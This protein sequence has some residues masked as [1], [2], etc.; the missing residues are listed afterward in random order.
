MIQHIVSALSTRLISYEA[1]IVLLTWLTALLGAA[2]VFATRKGDGHPQTLRGLMAFLL[3]QAVWRHRSPRLDV[4][5]HLAQHFTLPILAVPFLL[6]NGTA[7]AGV[8]HQLT[9]LFGAHA[10]TDASLPLWVAALAISLLTADFAT[11]AMHYL[12]HKI[13][14]LWD[15]HKTHH[16][17]EFLIPL[18]KHRIHPVEVVFDVTSNAALVGAANGVLAYVFS[19]PIYASTVLGLDVYFLANLLSFY[20]LRHS[21][22]DMSYGN[23]L[24]KW[25]LSPAQH[26]LHHSVEA[27]HWNHNFGLLLA[28]WDR[29]FGT[30]L[31]T[32]GQ[33][34]FRLGL[35]E[36][37]RAGYASVL[38]LY[39]TPLRDNFRRGMAMA[40]AMAAVALRGQRAYHWF[41]RHAPSHHP[42][43]LGLPADHRQ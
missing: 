28:V 27:R 31:L 40:R 33:G 9:T 30:L 17:V 8:Y 10:Q 41:P 22:I 43:P 23:W 4:L 14:V 42:E 39:V 36:A 3:P 20:H 24:E 5:F 18:S 32:E 12:S 7:A 11:F 34:R 26:Q 16:S 37:E 21:H 25:L 15:F 2:M 38:G 6:A 29:L 1:G 35:P 19:M 13:G